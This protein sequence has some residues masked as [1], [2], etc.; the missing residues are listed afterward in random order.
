MN[1]LLARTLTRRVLTAAAPALRPSSVCLFHAARSLSQKKSNAPD[2][3]ML[4]RNWEKQ[5]ERLPLKIT[6]NQLFLLTGSN[7]PPTRYVLLDGI[8][9]TIT[10][11]DIMHLVQRAQIPSEEVESIVFDREHNRIHVI[12]NA[13]VTFTS[14]EAAILFMA[15][16][17]NSF[18]GG[19]QLKG[20][21]VTC[22][23]FKEHPH[24]AGASG[25]SVLITGLPWYANTEDAK[26]LQRDRDP[27]DQ[28]EPVVIDIPPPTNA[29]S[30]HRFII[31]L[32]NEEKAYRFARNIHG[33]SFISRE[34]DDKFP[35]KAYVLY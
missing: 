26:R 33:R 31:Q 15:T 35:I 18:L 7:D 34:S 23:P 6:E 4:Q 29:S 17:H 30:S 19:R 25:R 3:T 27:S 32:E 13:A 16:A 8:N 20:K 14:P 28:F 9:N 2:P 5:P 21:F 12:R 1:N 11:R 10:T 22:E 24:V